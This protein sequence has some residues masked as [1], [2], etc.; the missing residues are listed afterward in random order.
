MKHATQPAL[1]PLHR[2]LS[3]RNLSKCKV[4]DNSIN[5]FHNDIFYE[6]IMRWVPLCM[7][8]W[9][10]AEFDVASNFLKKQR[11]IDKLSKIGR[12]NR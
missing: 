12:E 10:I 2:I 8:A 5:V 6:Q 9:R 7:A 3:V 1:A 4:L 11:Y